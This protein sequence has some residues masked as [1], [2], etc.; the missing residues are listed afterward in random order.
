MPA[1]N[2][3]RSV[4]A[5]VCCR[6]L[7]EVWQAHFGGNVDEAL[8]KLHLLRTAAE[9]EECYLDT[10]ERPPQTVAVSEVAHDHLQRERYTSIVDEHVTSLGGV[11]HQGA[12]RLATRAE[13]GRD[14]SGDATGGG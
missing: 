12:R 7:H 6:L 10:S 5:C 3:S 11:S 8:L 14:T 9:S 13:C 2:R 4:A 1:K